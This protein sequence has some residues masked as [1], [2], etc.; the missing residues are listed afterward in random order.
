RPVLGSAAKPLVDGSPCPAVVPGLQES[1]GG[2]TRPRD[3]KSN[4]AGREPGGIDRGGVRLHQPMEMPPPPTVR[5]RVER[6]AVRG[7]PDQA[8]RARSEHEA[9]GRS[10][11]AEAM[12]VVEAER[13][14]AQDGPRRAAVG[15]R[16]HRLWFFAA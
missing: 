13:D 7:L 10:D 16:N 4:A 11:P 12:T 1:D 5:G 2:A 8:M 6:D 3:R 9:V 14:P 15:G